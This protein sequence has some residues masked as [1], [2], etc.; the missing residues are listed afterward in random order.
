MDEKFKVVFTGRLTAGADVDAVV[1]SLISGFRLSE[2]KARQLLQR[3][4]P[5]VLKKDLP[6]DRARAFRDALQ[7]LGMD[8]RIEPMPPSTAPEL[9]LVPMEEKAQEGQEAP[10]AAPTCPK[11]GSQRLDIEQDTCLDC[12]IV[13]SKYRRIVAERGAE[14]APDPAPTAGPRPNPY[15]SPE[16]RLDQEPEDEPELSGPFALGIGAGWQWLRGGFDLFRENPGGW[17]GALVV[18]VVIS[19][20]ISFIPVAGSLALNLLSPVFMAGLMLGAHEQRQGGDFRVAHLFAGFSERAGPLLLLGLLYLLA[21]VVAALAIGSMMFAQLGGMEALQ[22]LEANA[23]PTFDPT[24][25]PASVVLPVLLV[26]A[27]MIPLLM[28]YWFSP[29]LIAVEGL[30]VWAALGQSFMACLKNILPFLW[31]GILATILMLLGSI[32]LGLGLLVVLPI[33]AGSVY[34]SYREIFYR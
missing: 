29:A 20:G 15:A 31:Y 28:A 10:E 17:I 9:T 27:L 23:P 24:I 11:C 25:D 2:E 22:T 18:L 12:G 26:V 16:A 19:I 6:Q 32:P 1:E 3:G 34:A 4:K 21:T 8:A 30:S 13:L 33:L 5:T 7:K 14:R